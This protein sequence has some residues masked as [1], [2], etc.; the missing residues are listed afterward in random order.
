MITVEN[1]TVRIRGNKIKIM[2]ELSCLISTL[3][4][5]DFMTEDDILRCMECA[6]MSEEEA[7]NEASKLLDEAFRKIFSSRDTKET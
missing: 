4:E 3:F 6:K 7:K 2:A 1:G 5:D